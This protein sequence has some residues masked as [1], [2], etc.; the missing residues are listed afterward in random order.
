MTSPAI[1]SP[2]FLVNASAYGAQEQPK[3]TALADGRFVAVWVDWGGNLGDTS[4]SAIRGQIFNA[5]GSKYG[6][7]FLV[8]T[9]TTFV[10][11]APEITAFADGKFAVTWTDASASVGDTSGEAI[12]AQMFNGDGSRYGTEI[13]VNTSTASIQYDPAISRFDNG[14][15]VVTWSDLSGV[16]DTSAQGVKAQLFNADGSRYG[17]EFLVNSTTAGGQVQSDVA[18]LAN[19]NFV[20]VFM[21]NSATGAD[22][23]GT[24]IRA[25]LFNS[26]GIPFAPDFV[27]N[28]TTAGSQ[29]VPEIIALSD[30][31]FVVTWVHDANADSSIRAQVFNAD[32]TPRGAEI[33]VNTKMDGTQSTPAVVA[34]PSG[35]FVVAWTDFTGTQSDVRAQVFDAN[36]AK[37]GGEFVTHVEQAEYQARPA[38]ATLADGR[39][40]VTFQDDSKTYG[41]PSESAIVAQIFDPR[42]H[43]QHLIGGDTLNDQLIGTAF[44]DMLDGRGGNDWLM[45]AAGNDTLDGGAGAD[46]LDGGEGIDTAWYVYSPAGVVVNLAGVNLF[47]DAA[48]DILNGIENVVGSNY[49]DILIGDA[50]DNQLAGAGGDDTIDGG[51]G[52]DRLAGGLGVNELEGGAGH[53]TALYSENFA[54]YDA[55]DYGQHVVIN[56]L[57]G[58]DTLTGIERVSFADGKVDLND[59]TVLFDALFYAHMNADVYHSGLNVFSHFNTYGWREGRDPNEFFDTSGYLAA[60][61]G[62]VGPNVNPLDHY[63]QHGWREG[64]DPSA[65]FDTKLYLIRNPDVAAAGIDP[66]E[67]YLAYGFSEGRAIY[68]AVGSQI[69]NGF[70][71]QYYLFHN[72]DVAA[73]GID[74]RA[75]YNAYGRHEG[76]DPNG[77]FD[78]S[79]YLA[80]YADVAAA[81]VN[82]LDHYMAYGWTEGR[83]A[84]AYFDTDG[85]L[86]NNPDDAAANINPLQHFLVYGIYE[87]RQAV[88]DGLWN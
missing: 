50:G 75:H 63:H 9:S 19:S 55:R 48:G 26:A 81:G 3:I 85:Y 84:S 4:D 21:D 1:W 5:N 42:T 16:G 41:D 49:R 22:T 56:G 88:N 10:Q 28:T 62:A 39:F 71:A 29:N 44:D 80:H 66:L 67:H 51:A 72:P 38:L 40:V 14:R 37:I 69:V 68:D 65:Y 8:N 58:Y 15:F 35:G 12:R 23:S 52:N 47:G 79:G 33:A 31:G 60:N 83:D 36:G 87:G 13:L 45:G 77:W 70:D 17:V 24:A 59:G 30:G 18:V 73:A 57:G 43:Y 53:D 6:G 78:T 2:A 11:N 27:V 20:A 74:A 86:T 46:R 76:R 32:A 61:R 82:P 7:E 54:D 34:L 25:R 64:R